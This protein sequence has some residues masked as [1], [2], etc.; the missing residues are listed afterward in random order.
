M[1]TAKRRQGFNTY[2][3]LDP[4]EANIHALNNIHE[5]FKSCR[6]IQQQS[7]K[8]DGGEENVLLN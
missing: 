6:I 5:A 3:V 7:G 1:I 4:R 2:Q 8:N